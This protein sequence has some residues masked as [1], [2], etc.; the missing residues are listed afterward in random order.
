MGVITNKWN[1]ESGD[2]ITIESPSFKGNQSVS[3]NSPV[4]QAT[5]KRSMVFIGKCK[6]DPTKTVKLIIEQEAS[7][8]TYDFTLNASKLIIPAGGGNATITG[9]LKTYRNG[10]L[11]NTEIVTPTISGTAEGFSISNNVVTASN[12]TTTVGETRSIVITG[13][14]NNTFDGQKVQ[15]DIIILQEANEISYG[16]VS[17]SGGTVSEIP[18]SGGSISSASGISASQTVTYTSGSTRP[19]SVK[20]T[21][22]TAVTAASKR[23]TISNRTSA[24]TLTATATGEGTKSASKSLTVYQVGN[25]VTK[26]AYSGGSLSY[27]T[28]GAGATSASPSILGM[29]EAFYYSS[30]SVGSSAPSSTYGTYVITRKFSLGSV[31]NGFSSVDSDSGVLTATNRGTTVGDARTSGVVTRTVTGV[32]TPTTGY[33]AGGTITVTGT[34]TATCT[35]EANTLTW[36]TPV[37]SR[38]TPVSIAATGGTNNVAT[39]LTYSQKGTYSS[40]STTSANSGGTLS[41]A[42]QTAKTG[43]SLFGSTVTVTNN[44]SLSARNG[45]IVRITLVL[46][47]KT[48]TKDITYNQAAGYYTYANPVVT[49]KCNDVPAK[50]GSVT[51]GTATYSQTYGWNGATSGVGTITSGGSISWSGGASNIPSLGTTPK[52]RS[53]VGTK[54]VATVT[55]NDKQGS[56]SVDVYQEKN[57]ITNSNYNPHITA[58][59]TPVISIGSGITA[60]GGS[61]TVTHSVSNTETYYDYYT[62]GSVGPAKTR[63][64]AGTSTISIT[65]NGNN[66]FSLSGNTVSHSSMGTNEVTDTVTITAKNAGDNSK[67]KTTSTSVTNN[68]KVQGTSGGVTTYEDVIA[69][70]ITDGTIPASGGSATATAGNGSQNWSK[71]AVITTY[72]YDSGSTKNET[73]SNATSGTNS[74]PPSISS[75]SASASTKGT[76]VSNV[77]TVKSQE[78]TWTGLGNKSKTGVMQIHQVANNIESYEY[79]N[80]TISIS[81]NPTTIAAS[82]GT[83]TITRNCTRTKTAVYTSGSKGSATTESATP[84]LSI[85]GNGFTLSGTTVTASKN[86]VAARTATVTASYSGAT[87]KSVTITQSAGPDGIGYMQIEGNGVD[88]YIFQVG[89]TPNTRFN[90]VQ[91]LSEEPVE[92]ATETKSESLFAKIKRIITDLN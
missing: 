11:I 3:I 75:I 91:T 65:A 33:S 45:F 1:D 66:R 12:R 85:S 48:A 26:I 9:T 16:N 40:G 37:I 19:G 73:T 24:G 18:A 87:S 6:S 42:V 63:S 4:Q 60:A 70:K 36:G 59:G 80:W 5:T 61:A 53:V 69:G 41:Y 10:T 8:Y 21:Y 77:T 52:E 25:Y 23:T 58:Y 51:S 88:H 38:T 89:R 50:G 62:S 15:S 90:D 86:N 44:T 78:V 20:I 34:L 76:T 67:T 17:I 35:Q 2:S 28:I 47:G 81:A 57:E 13:T 7:T 31:I 30:G 72:I 64:V 82:G 56:G 83:S 29:A 55:L 71:T 92:V 14:Y 79:G 22:S 49:V 54:L 68:K 43:F 74:I 27:P 84:S 32:W 39:G 46:N